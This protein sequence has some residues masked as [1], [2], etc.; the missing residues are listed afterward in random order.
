MK[1]ILKNSFKYL[2]YTILPFSLVAC[3][4]DNLKELPS[5]IFPNT[6]EMV[7]PETQQALIYDENGT[8]VLP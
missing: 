7:I 6:V 2:L 1:Y 3:S 5:A 8:K 4:D